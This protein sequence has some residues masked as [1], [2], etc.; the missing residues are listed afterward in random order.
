MNKTKKI[1]NDETWR[2]MER[3]PRRKMKK[4]QKYYQKWK[5]ENSTCHYSTIGVYLLTFLVAEQYKCIVLVN[6]GR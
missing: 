6:F 5:K 1:K 3:N 2:E 4:V